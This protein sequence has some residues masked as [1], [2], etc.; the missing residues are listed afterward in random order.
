V[1]VDFLTPVGGLLALAVLLPL[2]ILLLVSRR[3]HRIRR[4]L[5]LP[6]PPSGERLVPLVAL[7]VLGGLLGLAAAQPLLERT[8]TRRVRADAEVLVVMDITR[9]MLAQ[10]SIDSPTR[11]DRAKAAAAELRASLPGVPVGLASMTNRVLPH[12][13]PSADPDVFRA[14][15]ERVIG[16]ERP[17]PGTSFLT[18]EQ[19]R[20]KNATSLASLGSIAGR[21]FFS[22]TSTRRLLVVL[23]DGESPQVAAPSVGRSIQ[24]AKADAIFVQFWAPN[25][26][27]FTNGKPEAR[28]HPNPAARSTLEQLAATTEG[29]VYSESQLGAAVRDARAVIGSGPTV[30]QGRQPD[31]MPLAPYLAIV[32]FIPLTL[33]LLRRDR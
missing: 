15:L 32:A 3:A 5:L 28:Y 24:K 16:I 23:T 10:R 25:E 30:D 26:K 11:L 21:R 18:V 27:V 17:P 6:D 8:T 19:L 13:F 22:P 20:L 12:L 14:T 4:V 2:A 9:S 7:L 29:R 1:T 31:R 33:L